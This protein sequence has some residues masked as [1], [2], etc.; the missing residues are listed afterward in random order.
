MNKL[1]AFCVVI[2]V[3]SCNCNN[4]Q[5]SKSTFEKVDIEAILSQKENLLPEMCDIVSL[6]DLAQIFKL[7]ESEIIKRNTTPSESNPKQRTCFFKW[8]DPNYPNTAIMVQ[9]LRNPLGDEYPNYIVE[10]MNTKRQNGENTMNGDGPNL[11][12]DIE[13]MADEA[14]Y[15]ADIGKYFWRF[16]DK[17]LFHLAFN[18][19]HSNSEQLEM[20]TKLGDKMIENYLEL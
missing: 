4:G 14:I 13:S 19:N 5:S 15:N 7:D 9:A 11:F 17:V 2:I 10:I 6:K 3:S 8:E 1:L 18:T 20:A 16:S 12:S